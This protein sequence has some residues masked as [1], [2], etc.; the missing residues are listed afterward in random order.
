MQHCNL[1]EPLNKATV[2]QWFTRLS[3]RTLGRSS[4]NYLL[5]HSR[6]NE[7]YKLSKQGKMSKDLALDFMG[8]TKEMSKVYTHIKADEIKNMMK[9]QVYHLE[10]LPPEKKVEFEKRIDEQEKILIEVKNS[11]EDLAKDNKKMNE[12]MNEM[13][14]IV[15][16]ITNLVKE[17]DRKVDGR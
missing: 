7:L 2:N 17:H 10:E 12:Q 6:G 13:L 8:H 16:G 15:D 3:Q 11:N 14:K 1:N 4:W 5:R 9:E